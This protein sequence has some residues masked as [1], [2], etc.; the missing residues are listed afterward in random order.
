M[1]KPNEFEEAI[2]RRKMTIDEL[3]GSD[4]GRDPRFVSPLWLPVLVLIFAAFFLGAWQLI[5]I[6][7]AFIA[8]PF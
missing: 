3:E 6:A 7:R 4:I 8:G 2:A 1:T 5:Q